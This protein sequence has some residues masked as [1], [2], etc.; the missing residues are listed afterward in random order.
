MPSVTRTRWP[1]HRPP[2]QPLSSS[3]VT[4]PDIPRG[5]AAP[6]PGCPGGGGEPI[7]AASRNAGT[8][9]PRK[10]E[11]SLMEDLAGGS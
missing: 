4:G 10:W 2:D 11:A 7:T 5:P 9:T 1:C 6:G 3:H 8:F